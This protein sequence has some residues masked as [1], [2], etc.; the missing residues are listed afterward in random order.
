MKLSERNLQIV[1]MH[2]AGTKKVKIA[3]T[4]KISNS[5]VNQILDEYNREREKQERY[6][7]GMEMKLFV[8]YLN[9]RAIT[10]QLYLILEPE[11]T[12]C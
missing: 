2:I 12:R 3:K 6:K 1:R 11:L 9:I 4:F 7:E 5:R 8:A 10:C